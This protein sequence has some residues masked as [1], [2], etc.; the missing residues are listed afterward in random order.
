MAKTLDFILMLT[1]HD[2][3]VEDCLEV[4]DSVTPLGLRHIGFKDTGVDRT[5]L[6]TLS[7]RI[8]EAGCTSYM[9]IVSTTPEACLASTRLAAELGVDRLLG[10][11]QAKEILAILKDT[12]VAYYPFPGRPRGH[13][14]LLDGSPETIAADASRLAA[15]GC[16]GLDLLAYRATT[17]QPEDLVRAARAGFPRGYLI[18]A[19]SI[20]SAAQIH[21]I[22]DAGADA[23]TIGSAVFEGAFTPRKAGLCAQIRDVL[24]ACA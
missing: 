21:A 22:A 13:P 3:T 5:T 9:E 4:L 2:Q 10:G 20:R 19:G 7:K 16:A 18:V 1:R 14:T 15:L 12:R 8:K 17:A 23:F 11:T 24:A 6:R